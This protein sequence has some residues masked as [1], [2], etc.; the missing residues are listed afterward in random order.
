M[1]GALVRAYWLTDASWGIRVKALAALQRATGLKD[2]K[3]GKAPGY[4]DWNDARERKQADVV[5][6]FLKAAELTVKRSRVAA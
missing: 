5:N 3:P 4:G 2:A 6:A 1:Y